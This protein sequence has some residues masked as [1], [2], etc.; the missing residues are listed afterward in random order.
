LRADIELRGSVIHER[1]VDQYGFSGSYQRV[2]LFLHEARP[3]IAAELAGDESPLGGCIAGSRSCPV[4]RLRSTGATRASCCRAGCG[5]TPDVLAAYRQTGKGRVERQVAIVREHVLA[6][7]V[8]TSPADLDA[9]FAAWLPIRR[10]QVHRTHGEVIAARAEADRAALGALPA[11]PY[12]VADR[13]LRR[14]G[15]DCLVSFEASLYSVPAA[16][17]RAG[18]RVEVSAFGTV[19]VH[20][21]PADT[22]PEHSSVLAVHTGRPDG[23]AGW[24]TRR[25]GMNC[26]TATARHGDARPRTG[27]QFNHGPRAP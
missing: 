1:L 19:T 26:L 18:P 22:P 20:S 3:R 7:R 17:V 9:A 5:S 21:L 25:T 4:R 14:V 24:S 8:F 6:G 2:K 11:L 13:C 27:R 23:A 10:G 15:K 12:L 16:R